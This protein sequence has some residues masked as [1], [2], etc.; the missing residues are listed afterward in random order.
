VAIAILIAAAAITAAIS[1]FPPA[2]AKPPGGGGGGGC[3]CPMV[4]APVECDNGKTYSNQ[5]VANCHNAK[6]CV[7]TGPGPIEL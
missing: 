1:L 2:E 5:C 6:N 4:W 3:I 7:P